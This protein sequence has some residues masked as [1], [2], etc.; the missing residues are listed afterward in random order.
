MSLNLMFN[1]GS[2][3]GNNT[4]LNYEPETLE[5]ETETECGKAFIEAYNTVPQTITTGGNVFFP[6]VTLQENLDTNSST[7]EFTIKSDGIYNIEI[8]IAAAGTTTVP[9]TP[10]IPQFSIFVN[11]VFKPSTTFVAVQG[12]LLSLKSGDIVTVRNRSASPTV[13]TNTN[14]GLDPSVTAKI[15]IFKI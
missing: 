13:V 10:S 7:G 4:Y 3:G 8:G 2:R 11:G 5:T 6:V 14:A 1:N 15:V 12:A 9:P